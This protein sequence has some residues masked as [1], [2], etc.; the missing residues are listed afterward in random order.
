VKNKD[1]YRDLCKIETS[2]PIFSKDWWLD[3]VVGEEN[4]D[5]VLVEKEDRIVASLPYVLKKRVI[6]QYISMPKLTQTAGLWIR[7]PQKQ[8]Y[9]D[10]LSFEKDICTSII[11]HLPNV[12][13]FLQN[14]HYSFTNW[15]PFYWKGYSQTTRYTYV[16]EDL[17]N[18][19]NVY[20]NFD[21]S[22]KKDIKKAMKHVEVGFDLTAKE[23]YENHKLTLLKQGKK[24]S[25]PFELFENIYN[26]VYKN[27]AGRIIWAKDKEQ[28]LHSALFVIWDE[29]SAYDLISTI[30]P[31]Y[32]FSGS[33]SLLI[34]NIIKYVADKTNKFDFEGSM[35]E[36]VERSFR[37][38]GAVQKPYFTIYKTNSRL[39]KIRNGLKEVLK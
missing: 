3:S 39:L 4:W 32:R 22:K 7:Y 15:L 35:I 37:K 33:A 1:K 9:I 19:E 16:I 6:F 38:F 14:F 26:A 25:Y 30:D 31:E 24:I 27:H 29:N 5:V 13:Y 17:S 10:K 20:N 12:D 28:R 34:S 2:I 11:D 23:F 21:R 8:N 18:L 36:N